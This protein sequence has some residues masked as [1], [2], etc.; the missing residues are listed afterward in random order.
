MKGERKRL[1]YDT[2]CRKVKA[3]VRFPNTNT[4]VR[5]SIDLNMN[6]NMKT[7]MKMRMKMKMPLCRVVSLR[8]LSWLPH[9]PPS[10]NSNRVPIPPH[11]CTYTSYIAE[12]HLPTSRFSVNLLW[13]AFP[14]ICGG[15]QSSSLDGA[16]SSGAS[17]L[18]L[19][20]SGTQDS[21]TVHFSQTQSRSVQEDR[22]E[23]LQVLLYVH[24]CM[25]FMQSMHRAHCLFRSYCTI[26]FT[27]LFCCI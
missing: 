20:A 14:R 24:A 21:S 17:G 5:R 12:T 4:G 10:E 9:M 27:S 15:E 6:L 11:T 18:S 1:T 3:R 2:T 8:P 26:L 23:A 7:K 19:S 25:L 22:A 13:L 16:R